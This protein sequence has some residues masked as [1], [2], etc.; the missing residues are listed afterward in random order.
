MLAYLLSDRGLLNSIRTETDPTVS[1]NNVD[2]ERLMNHCPRLESVF[3]ETLRLTGASSSVRRVIAP[4]EIGGKVLRSGHRVIIPYRQ[5]HLNKDVYGMDVNEFD[6]DRFLKNRN[7]NHHPSYR[8][9]GGGA[10]Y[11]P[12]RFIARQEVNVFVALL[13]SRFEI[14]ILPEKG[15]RDGERTAA[16]LPVMDHGKPCLGVLRPK[17]GE[18]IILSVRERTV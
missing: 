7:L 9:F 18:D 15:R 3:Y 1:D 4:T 16:R 8:P 12:G 17:R 14:D 5:L 11:C 13:L 6:P 10:N 2:L